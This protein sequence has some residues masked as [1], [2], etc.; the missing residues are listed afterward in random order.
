MRVANV[1]RLKRRIAAMAPAARDEIRAALDKSGGEIA[2]AARLLVPKKTG[3]L[4]RSIGHTLGPVEKKA[5]QLTASG[6]EHDLSVTIHAGS[7]EAFYA[8]WVEFG[9]APGVSGQRVGARNSDVKQNRRQ[10]RKSYRTH[11]GTKEQPFFFPAYRLGRKRAL[12]RIVRAMNKA[13]KKAAA[14]S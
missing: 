3:A 9:T 4:A 5:G 8:R 13:A 1:G 12:S 11:P 14:A 2:G 10:G 7:D 6:G